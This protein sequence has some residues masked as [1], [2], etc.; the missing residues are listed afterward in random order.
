MRVLLLGALGLPVEAME[1]SS[2]VNGYGIFSYATIGTYIT[3]MCLVAGF[4]LLLGNSI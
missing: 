1:T 3:V 4:L 2:A